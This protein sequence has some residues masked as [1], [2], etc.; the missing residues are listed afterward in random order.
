[1][2]A[3]HEGWPHGCMLYRVGFTKEVGHRPKTYRLIVS[4]DLCYLALDLPSLSADINP[5]I[6]PGKSK[7]P[8]DF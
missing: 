6:G 2:M 4:L 5:R 1:M 8:H 3:D 7:R